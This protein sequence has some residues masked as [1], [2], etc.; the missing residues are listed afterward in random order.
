[1]EKIYFET[2]KETLYHE[3]MANGLQVYLL[4]KMGF[5]KTYGLFSTKFGAIDTTFIP[6]N[7]DEMIK[8][9]D[10]IA[11]F[12]EHKMFDMSDG[13]ASEKFAKLG[14]STN[15]FTSSIP[16]KFFI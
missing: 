1:M 6:L 16:M 12:L 11:H 13:D 15:A 7:K 10:G 5:E 9:E 14:A 4:P 2:L 3:K 8:V